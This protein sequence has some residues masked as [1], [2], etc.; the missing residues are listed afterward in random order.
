MGGEWTLNELK[1]ISIGII[2]FERAFEAMVPEMHR[3]NQF[4]RSNRFFGNEQLKNLKHSECIAMIQSQKSVKSLAVVM[5]PDR[6]TTWNFENLKE[7]SRKGT[8]EF[9]Q[10]PGQTHAAGCL[11]WIE[12]AINFVRSA[13][14][15]D[16]HANIREYPQTVSGLKQFVMEGF[17]EGLSKWNHL[18]PL[19]HSKNA[20]LSIVPKAPEYN[21]ALITK[22]K[23][24]D[25]K[26]NILMEKLKESIKKELKTL[27]ASAS[28]SGQHSEYT[29][30]DQRA[31][32]CRREKR[33]MQR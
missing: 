6:Y 25:K 32:G 3:G 27:L 1:G 17:V 20:D 11:S 30:E 26:K 12:L 5:S 8:L 18:E 24:E 21:V 4:I 28:G 7:D 33:R 13:R 2:H 19:M 31:R 10:P 16:W 23:R 14:R 9:R 15:K 22:K 29:D